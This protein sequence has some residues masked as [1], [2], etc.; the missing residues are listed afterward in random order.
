VLSLAFESRRDLQ[1]ALPTVR[2]VLDGDGIVLLP[3]E[4]FYGLAANPFSGTAVEKIFRLKARPATM[5]LP[6]LAASVEDVKRLCEIPP[7]H[8]RWIL[9]QWPGP[10]TVILPLRIPLPAAGGTDLAVRVPG[11]DLLRRLLA[12]TGPLTGTSANLHGE[13]PSRHA[14]AAMEHLNGL[15]DLLLDGGPTPGKAASSIIR[16]SGNDRITVR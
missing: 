2:S 14:G 9:D 8:H 1:S 13:P 6:V 12:R 4:T 16:F 3:T 15:P 11:H 5:P 10:V 7:Q